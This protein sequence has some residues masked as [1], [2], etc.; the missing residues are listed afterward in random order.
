MHSRA[1]ARRVFFHIEPKVQNYFLSSSL[2]NI[3]NKLIINEQSARC[4]CLYGHCK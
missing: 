4:I 3:N 1:R 2:P